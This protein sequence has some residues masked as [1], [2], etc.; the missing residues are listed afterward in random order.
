MIVIY[1]DYFDVRRSYTTKCYNFN[2]SSVNN[3]RNETKRN[4][5]DNGRANNIN[6]D[7]RVFYGSIIRYF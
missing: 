6:D 4:D 2:N 1:F 3:D 7:D 5:D